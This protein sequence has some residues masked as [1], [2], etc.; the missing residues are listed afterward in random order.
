[1]TQNTLKAQSKSF[2]SRVRLAFSTSRKIRNVSALARKLQ[3]PRTSVSRAINQGIFPD[4]QKEIA[5]AL[6]LS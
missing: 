5:K 2:G 4:L 1:M 6:K 3:R